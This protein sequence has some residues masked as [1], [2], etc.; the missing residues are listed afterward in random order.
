MDDSRLRL[1]RLSNDLFKRVGLWSSNQNIVS[2]LVKSATLGPDASQGVNGG[3]R[4]ALIPGLLLK[5]FKVVK[6]DI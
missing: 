1:D 2:L 3:S 4:V 6:R 5:L